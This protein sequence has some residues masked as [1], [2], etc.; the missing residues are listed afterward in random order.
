MLASVRHTTQTGHHYRISD[1]KLHL[2]AYAWWRSILPHSENHERIAAVIEH[3]GFAMDT[4]TGVRRDTER[5]ITDCQRIA[6]QGD[7]VDEDILTRGANLLRCIVGNPYRPTPVAYSKE[8]VDDSI[9]RGDHWFWAGW[10]TPTVLSL[11]QAA[12]EERGS[13]CKVCRGKGRFFR[14]A[15]PEIKEPCVACHGTGRTV[16]D[17]TLDATRLAILA[18][19]LQDVGCPG[20]HEIVRHLQ[21][22]KLCPKCLGT[23]TI[24]TGAG[25][26]GDEYIPCNLCEATGRIRSDAPHVRG[27]CCVDTILGKE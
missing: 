25:D 3:P 18:D 10:R 21:G 1:H 15:R 7:I 5:L 14:I 19:A 16:T 2:F 13:E 24:N 27:C 12:Y 17:G 20:N 11:A 26:Y 22:W 9:E 23:K 6:I 4:S 8:N